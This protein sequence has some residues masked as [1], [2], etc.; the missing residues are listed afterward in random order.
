MQKLIRFDWAIKTVLRK[1]DN[2]DILEAFI[3]DLINKEVKILELLESE[4]NQDT[5]TD[6]FNRVDI[7]VK[8]VDNNRYIIEV[9]NSEEKDYLQRMLYGTSK[10]IVENISIGKSYDNI[11]KVISINIV[12]FELGTGIDTVYH[13][14]MQFIGLNTKTLLNDGKQLCISTFNSPDEYDVKIFPEYYIILPNRFSGT[15]KT[16]FDEWLYLLKN[17]QVSSNS[18][19]DIMNK[20]E[21][22]LDILNMQ[23]AER[24]SYER[25]IESQV[26][27]NSH[28]KSAEKNGESR[29]T[30][31]IAT[32]LLDVLDDETIAIKTGLSIEKV[33]GLRQQV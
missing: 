1:K 13:G 9:Q 28:I 5:S 18:T 26:I 7:L 17:S 21:V 15:T 22:Q 6:K 11:L 23:E 27:Y 2:F 19:S 20:I 29:K 12:Y 3:S 4:S 32:A 30:L 16:K 14:E 10:N 24:K 8:D 25:F 33:A 31:E